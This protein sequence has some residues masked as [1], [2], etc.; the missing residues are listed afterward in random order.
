LDGYVVTQL[1]FVA[2]ELGVAR[3]LSE[4]PRTGAEIADAVGADPAALTR[5][6]RGLARGA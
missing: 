2:E 6:L 5:V 1:L 4:G 3:V